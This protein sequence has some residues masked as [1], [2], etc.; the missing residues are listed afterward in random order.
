MKIQSRGS[1][2]SSKTIVIWQEEIFKELSSVYPLIKTFTREIVSGNYNTTI[3]NF[4]CALKTFE[5]NLYIKL[6]Y[7]VLNLE[8]HRLPNVRTTG[9]VCKDTEKILKK[10]LFVPPEPKEDPLSWI[11]SKDDYDE[12]IIKLIERIKI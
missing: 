3:L 9:E 11:I 12:S 5:S 10:L 8:S 2:I 7:A 6:L 1:E 4:L